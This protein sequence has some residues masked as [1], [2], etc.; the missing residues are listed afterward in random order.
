MSRAIRSGRDIAI[1]GMAG[2]FPMSE[3]PGAFL[4]NIMIGKECFREVPASRWDSSLF[5]SK[6]IRM[7]DRTYSNRGAFLDKID[8][9]ASLH[10]GIPPK[11]A[12]VMDPQQR[13]LLEITRL[14]FQ[15]AGLE[16]ESLRV[17]N[18]G[19]V[20]FPREKTGVFIGN[21]TSEFMFIQLSRIMAIQL[22]GGQL[23]GEGSAEAETLLKAAEK[24]MPISAYS[25]SG[26]LLNMAAANI[27]H[28]WGLGGP[29]FT[30]DAA[31]ASSMAAICEAVLS[32]RT[33]I[34]DCAV[35]GGVYLNFSPL[36]Y[37]CFTRIGA[38]SVK[39][40][41]RPFDAE[42]DGF[43]QGEGCGVLILKRLEDA[44]EA[45]DEIHAVIRGVGM[46]NDGPDAAGSMA[47]SRKGQSKAVESAYV[48]AEVDF[49]AVDY[50]ECHSTGTKRG[51]PVEVGALKDVLAKSSSV[52]ERIFLGSVK[53]TLGHCMSAAGAASLIKTI[54]MMKNRVIPP[55]AGFESL[56]PA[57]EINGASPFCVPT[58]AQEWTYKGNPRRAGVSSLGFGGTNCHVVLEE[59]PTR[60]P[61]KRHLLKILPTS[62]PIAKHFELVILSAPTPELLALHCRET[63]EAVHCL[64]NSANLADIAF[65]LT[66]TRKFERYRLACV[67]SDK[68]ALEKELKTAAALLK[69]P[70]KANNAVA[71]GK[72]G[73]SLFLSDIEN[74][75][76]E[77][78]LQAIPRSSEEPEGSRVFISSLAKLF[79]TN[80]RIDFRELYP[81]GENRLLQLPDTPLLRESHWPVL[82]TPTHF[83]PI[84]STGPSRKNTDNDDISL[85]TVID[86][87]FVPKAEQ[88]SDPNFLHKSK[89]EA[90]TQQNSSAARKNIEAAIMNAVSKVSAFPEAT[91]KPAQ[92]LSDDLGFDSMMFVE[93]IENIEA[94]FPELK[95]G[96]PQSALGEETRI[97]DI[98]DYIEKELIDE[99]RQ[100][101]S[102]GAEG[103]ELFHQKPEV[104]GALGGTEV[105]LGTVLLRSEKSIVSSETLSVSTHPY[106]SDHRLRDKPVLPFASA[107]D[108]VART[109]KNAAP[110]DS[111]MAVKNMQ[112][113]TG[114]VVEDSVSM[115]LVL[116]V[117]DWGNSAPA[118]IS[119]EIRTPKPGGGTVLAYRALAMD[120]NEHSAE[121]DIAKKY[122]SLPLDLTLPLPFDLATFYLEHSFHGP[123]LRGIEK[124]TGLGKLCIAG[125]VK[126]SK[127]SDWINGGSHSAWT[128]DPMVIDASFQLVAFWLSAVHGKQAYPIGFDRFVLLKPF[129]G[130][131]VN[132][133]VIAD[134][135]NND[136]FSGTIVYRNENGE[137]SAVMEGVQARLLAN[138]IEGKRLSPDS[139]ASIDPAFFNVEEFP[140]IKMLK[141]RIANAE[142][143]GFGNTFFVPQNGVAADTTVINGREFINFSSYNYLGFSG[144]PEIGAAAKNAI[145]QYGTSVSASR[146][147]SGERPLH[148]KLESSIASL[149]HTEAALVFS[150]GHA[151]NESVIG[152]LMGEGDLIIHDSLA[153]NSIQQGA[154]MSGSR[155]RP[156]PHNDWEALD[157]LLEKLRPQFKKCL[158]V[159]EGVYSMDGDIPD[160]PK[161]VEVKKRHGCLLYVDEAHSIGVLGNGGGIREH[162]GIDGESADLWMG[163]LSKSFASC[164]GY[165]AGKRA[166]IEYLKFT[167]P[168]FV[169]SAGISPPNAAAA[170]AAIEKMKRRPDLV[171]RLLE[172]SAKFLALVKDIGVDAGLSHGSA[173]IPCI[174]G[175]SMK[176]MELSQRLAQRGI[177]VQ[178][179]VYPAVDEE[180]ARLRFFMS[181]LHSDSQLEQTAKILEKEANGLRLN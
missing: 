63:A 27:S 70:E 171:H 118:E 26:N 176:C 179:I 81:R 77:T 69:N 67:V 86:F 172:Q 132:C 169:F 92:A 140:E 166:L 108:Y 104:D 87:Q 72:L 14:A 117:K 83:R 136:G 31:C 22:A 158:V 88:E 165:I 103:I 8:E 42:A 57:M 105:L 181:A 25:M 62:S 10:F 45:G 112:L 16:A 89:P 157:N 7:D 141:S 13:L 1:I 53:G 28:Q 23:R 71:D 68:T 99:L 123:R 101:S 54:L 163:T 84:I 93:L 107:L 122:A 47:P 131:R 115:D 174:V 130:K 80:Q 133:L 128:V 6:S 94:A 39:G 32:L 48:D 21:S 148:S 44:V 137:I 35:A 167:T 170:I 75:G 135:D 52:P 17:K 154:M 82:E 61:I 162:F 114:V 120:E 73:E 24:I 49:A 91:L 109:L 20:V 58:K 160:L 97:S 29:S 95:N 144:D 126:T 33:G 79:A 66:A 30:M 76:N 102:H 124:V 5:Y 178:P 59:A 19:S 98:V 74:N 106:L 90:E 139:R 37:L 40:R 38:M 150:A 96:L 143:L 134:A 9:F 156:F 159:I 152:H 129:G 146:L 3:T 175:N 2:R 36:N 41:C 121:K 119:V 56:N 18:G 111:P 142:K 147:A 85:Q 145:D 155:R 168:G 173:I 55:Q 15:D 153:H 64:S 100:V 46:N 177:N 12:A 127:P 180:A 161:F 110:K 4:E 50:V 151:T 113:H 149:L 125:Q 65:T 78:A 51:D 34:C 43:L 164:G 116:H 11:Q 138:R 60:T